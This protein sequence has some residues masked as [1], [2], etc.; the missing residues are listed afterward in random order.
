VRVAR[1]LALLVGTAVVLSVTGMVPAGAA[2]GR[3]A[4]GLRLVV[5]KRSL[6]G[7]HSWYQQ[8]LNGR[9][10]LGGYLVRHVSSTTGKVTVDDGRVAVR[11][12][13]AS[14]A[15][16]GRTAAT[17]AALR[18]VT[19]ATKAPARADGAATLAVRPGALGRLVWD[20]FA[21]AKGQSWE[22]LVDATNGRVLWARSTVAFAEGQVFSPNPVVDQQDESL[23]DHNNQD[24]AALHASYTTVPL[25]HLDG[26]GYLHGDFAT[27][28]MNPRVQAFSP[29]GEFIYTRNK[30]QFE[31]TMAYY[32]VTTA[33]E[34]IQ[35]LGFTDVNNEPQDLRPDGVWYD[36]SFYSPHDDKITLGRGGVDDAED[37]EVTWH[38][39]GHAI[40]DDQVP[41]FGSNNSAG[42]IGEGFGDYWAFTMSQAD[43]PDTATTPLAC[44]ADWDS[45]SYTSG[46]PHCLRRVD[47]DHT[48][49]D[50]G[51]RKD[52]HLNGEIWSAALH[53]INLA[54]GRDETNTIVLESQF[55]F[56]PKISFQKAAQR[57]VDAA[58]ALFG[59]PAAQT[60]IQKFEARDIN[61]L[62]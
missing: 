56:T 61:G 6:L 52:V 31:Q 32:D 13:V 27:V 44:I 37:E 26:T 51:P 53:D 30:R 60:C 59:E 46:V 23:T 50:Y 36:N 16:V 19:R 25:T 43:S 17:Q 35:S 55:S 42:S 49:A 22:A 2:Q 39:Y 54:L 45:T 29:S 11:G 41:N 57:T 24:I 1:S 3:Q 18:A 10:V 38:E 14:K 34:Y 48:Y 5:V 7:R 40:Q 20:V 9:P 8:T 12:R 4:G 62:V 15:T 28:I 33:Q 47:T 21:L 58:R